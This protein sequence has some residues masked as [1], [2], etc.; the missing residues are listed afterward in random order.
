MGHAIPKRI[1]NIVKK[2]NRKRKIKTFV[3]DF[4]AAVEQ[5]DDPRTR[6][7]AIDYPLGEILF[8]A[9]VAMI[10]G[11]E[12]YQDFATF[13]N[14]QLTWLR[15][16]FPFTHG[17]PSHD[18]YRRVFELLH[19]KSLEKTYRMIISGLKVRTTKHIAIDGKTSRGCY[20]IKGQCLLHVVSAWDTD[21]GIALGQVSTHNDEDKDVGE[22]NTIPH[23]IEALDIRKAVVTI[24]AGGCYDNIV[25]V[26]VAGKGNYVITL[27]DNQPTLIEEA[28]RAFADAELNGSKEVSS[29]ETTDNKHGRKERRTY[30]VISVAKGSESRKKWKGLQSFVKVESHR[31]VKGKKSRE[32]RY[33]ISSL[34]S[35]QIEQIA[36]CV[37]LHWGIENSLHWVLDVS[38]GEDSNRTRCG[39][40][41]ENLSTLRR[42]A[43]GLMRR[44]KGKQTVPNMMFQAALSQT[45]RTNIVKQI[46]NEDS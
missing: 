2:D 1:V 43:V 37:R 23:V 14:A 45:F 16:F 6:K 39:H 30:Q 17:I 15:K 26:I 22:Y 31:E 40:G 36:R 20:N 4:N 13:G 38:F 25:K 42:L 19:P 34:S 3:S 21:N 35:N 24:D 32:T 5:I 41:A 18:T 44:V 46:V 33:L 28:K 9:L 29:I 8:T 12:S 7:G 11:S 27:K 10:C